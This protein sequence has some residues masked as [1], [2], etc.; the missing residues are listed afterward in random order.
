MILKSLEMQGFKSFPE[1]TVI[2]F[3]DGITAIVGP[4][5]SGKSNI[6]DAVRWVLGELSTKAL[7]G[8]KMEDVIFNGTHEMKP[9]SMA[10]VS[11]TVDNSA[12]LLPVA[13]AEVK[14]TRVITRSGE[15]GYYINGAQARLR[16]VVELFLNTG[17]G[18]EGYSQIGQGQITD[19]ISMSG[20][21]R[22]GLIEEAAGISK[23]RYRK[24]EALRKLAAVRDNLER[25]GDVFADL[26]ARVGPLAAEAEKA[27]KFLSLSEERKSIEI[28]LWTENTSKLR[29]RMEK[30]AA[31]L[32]LARH[33]YG[34]ASEDAD[35][36]E[37][38]AE[39]LF[40]ES[41]RLSLAIEEARNNHKELLLKIKQKESD[42]GLIANEDTHAQT[43]LEAIRSRRTVLIEEINAHNGRIGEKDGVIA[44]IEARL[45]EQTAKRA[46]A[47]TALAAA[48]ERTDEARTRLNDIKGRLDVSRAE[49]ASLRE[50]AAALEAGHEQLLR[51]RELAASQAEGQRVAAAE[52]KSALDAAEA[53]HAAAES[54]A[55]S[56]EA[57]LAG[58]IAAA[59]KA[60]DERSALATEL[61]GL[62]SQDAADSRLAQTRRSMLETLEGY[63]PG[64]KAVMKESGRAGGLSGIRGVLSQLIGVGADYVTAIETA[65]GPAVQNIVV[66]DRDAAVAAINFLKRTGGGRATF[67]P[68]DT[69]KGSA[70][71]ARQFNKYSNMG[72][73]G[74]ASELVKCDPEYKSIIE[75][76]LGR[77]LVCDTIENAS[78]IARATSYAHRIV[79]LDGQ[80]VSAGGA[81]TGGSRAKGS[82]VLAGQ[83][84]LDELERRIGEIR[85][86]IAR[87]EKEL[88]EKTARSNESAK[89]TE[90]ARSVY[91]NA[92][93]DAASAYAALAAAK[94]SYEN[95]AALL[96]RMTAP[97]EDDGS[98][99]ERKRLL[100]E[101]I[102][103]L[104]VAVRDANY[105]D[106]EAGLRK[107]EEERANAQVLLNTADMEILKTRG[108]R[109]LEHERKR[110]LTAALETSTAQL[111]ADRE[112]QGELIASRRQLSERAEESESEVRRMEEESQAVLAGVKELEGKRE[113]AEAAAVAGRALIRERF[114]VKE[115]HAKESARAENQSAQ[116]EKDFDA[117]AQR[118]WE[119]YELTGVQA[120]ARA[121]ELRP[122]YEGVSV[123]EL[124]RRSNALKAQVKELGYVNV[125]AIDEYGEV[126]ER[127]IFM[128][129]QIG[130]LNN[131]I[132]SLTDLISRMDGEMREKLTASLTR[133][134]D[135]YGRVFSELFGGGDARLSVSGSEDVLECGIE[136]RVQPPGKIIKNLAAL[137]GGEQAFAAIALYFALL[138]ENPSPFCVLDEIETA[139]DDVNVYKF[140]DYLRRCAGR[141]QFVIITHRRGTMEAAD[142]LYGVTMREKGVSRFLTLDVADAM[143]RAK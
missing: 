31:D 83:S 131:S 11:L 30:T 9:A 21:E 115:A 51:Q 38:A 39:T 128:K 117:H 103:R 93:K 18:R 73:V 85:A 96:V 3:E 27:R 111:A 45:G 47:E 36:A 120:Q 138:E 122:Q 69:I 114:N 65:L 59:K 24:E 7:R 49:L 35:R 126:S 143:R 52:K 99:I 53:A 92:R 106:A 76:L 41:Q 2:S 137:S 89:H 133:I 58:V 124:N 77:T 15:S 118:M 14:I 44:E 102:V 109:D 61:T 116:A 104:E 54:A 134:N 90:S 140:A 43:E 42:I 16:D 26:E 82:S 129:T 64:V 113:E 100:E 78:E 33:N 48:S 127:Y 37:R 132:A 136:I 119:E 56:A 5:G 79:T 112:R 46:E 1:R 55:K 12:G 25:V 86:K 8:G 70:L 10:K 68:M 139:L 66:T 32:R 105:D 62:K 23:V 94:E 80:Q 130:D 40:N 17:V 135:S 101:G 108:E 121:A 67:Y 88:A 63:Y 98:Y 91:E 72:F 13:S 50:Q 87:L 142:R 71:D 95:A 28:I 81:F 34:L 29:A 75:Y 6:A 84:E 19:V 107:L 4:N 110:A 97:Q 123:T 141:T 125:N 60:E 74:I 20:E 57:A 22:R